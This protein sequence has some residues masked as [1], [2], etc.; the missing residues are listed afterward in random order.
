MVVKKGGRK[1][2]KSPTKFHVDKYA[3]LKVWG[4]F[5]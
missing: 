1:C 4:C 3:E 5:K 2:K